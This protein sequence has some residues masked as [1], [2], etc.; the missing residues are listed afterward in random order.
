M[1]YLPTLL[2][3]VLLVGC[4]ERKSDGNATISTAAVQR[5]AVQNAPAPEPEPEPGPE[6]PPAKRRFLGGGG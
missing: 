2:C 6:A 4:L 3:L 5:A 1:K